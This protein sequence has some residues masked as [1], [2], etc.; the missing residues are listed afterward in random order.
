MEGK[1]QPVKTNHLEKNHRK[2][3]ERRIRKWYKKD[4]EKRRKEKEIHKLKKEVKEKDKVTTTRSSF[5]CLIR[6]MTWFRRQSIE[7]QTEK[8]KCNQRKRVR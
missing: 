7:G 4:K 6:N 3:K 2:K 1:R 5:T 8:D